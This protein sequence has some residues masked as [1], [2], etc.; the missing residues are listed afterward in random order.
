[1]APLLPIA[2]RFMGV[3]DAF[4]SAESARCVVVSAPI[5]Y[6][7]SYGKGSD[8]GPAAIIEAS[9][10]VEL[11]DCELACAPYQLTNGIYTAPPLEVESLRPERQHAIVEEAVGHWLDADKFV[12]TLG[13]EHTSALGPIRAHLDRF[14]NLTILQLDAHSDLR[15]EYEGSP[16]NHAC[17][18][19]R[20]MERD[21]NL[22]QVGIRSQCPEEVE[23]AE[24]RDLPVF[25]AHRVHSKA[26]AGRPWI[27]DI[28][29]TLSEN[30]YL[31]F[32]CDVFDPT[33]MP[34]TGTPEPGGLTWAQ[35]DALMAAVC[36]HRKLIGFDVTELA[37]IPGLHHPQ[38]TVAKLIYRLI[39]RRFQSCAS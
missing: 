22:V 13:G 5:E 28:L 23:F 1:M 29:M 6:S 33:I 32:D 2:Q 8:L 10:Q 17:I 38:F 39:G 37:P 12:V 3:E 20:V 16:L 11:Y 30:V 35:V 21:V 4:A 18:M 26:A 36:M 25:H 19:A 34:A 24:K 15:N 14:E 9:T 7:S 27:E 31:S